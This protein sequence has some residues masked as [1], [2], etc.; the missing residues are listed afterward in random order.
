MRELRFS[1]EIEYLTV[2]FFYSRGGKWRKNRRAASYVIQAQWF[3]GR[4]EEA[5]DTRKQFSERELIM[6]KEDFLIHGWNAFQQGDIEELCRIIGRCPDS[7]ERQEAAYM[8]ILK[9]W[10]AILER[11][12]DFEWNPCS[13]TGVLGLDIHNAYWAGFWYMA[14]GKREKAVEQFLYVWTK[15]D[16]TQLAEKARYAL[17]GWGVA[18]PEQ[19]AV[20]RRAF[21]W[22]V[23]RETAIFVVTVSLSLILG[24]FW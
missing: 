22:C 4:F 3:D 11:N 12:W 1:D 20:P 9:S 18:L 15:G 16:Q 21:R 6:G 13:T 8:Q 2:D 17:E 23:V 7:A 19:E 5:Y 24:S 14:S 10:Q